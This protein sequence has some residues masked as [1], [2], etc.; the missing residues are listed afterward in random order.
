MGKNFGPGGKNR[1]K[2][3]NVGT[4]YKREMRW[5]DV[6]EEYAL[7]EKVL[8]DC[9]VD[10]LCSDGTR[11]LCH[12]R[13]KFK[14]RV[15]ISTGDIVLI[16]LRDFEDGKADI[17][18]KYTS[19]EANILKE[20]KEISFA[21]QDTKALLSTSNDFLNDSNDENDDQLLVDISTI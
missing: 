19:D 5:K 3:K 1:R 9:R 17:I 2:G 8:G 20:Q 10:C 14:K 7:V 18:H 15:W 16:S 11:R 21:E 6:M 12:I 4:L 13:G